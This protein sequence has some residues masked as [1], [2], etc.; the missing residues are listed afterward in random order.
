[1]G[2]FDV[3]V[4]YL[5]KYIKAE[6]PADSPLKGKE[7]DLVNIIFLD[8][9]ISEKIRIDNYNGLWSNENTEPSQYYFKDSRYHVRAKDTVIDFF[10]L[11]IKGIILDV[12]YTMFTQ[13]PLDEK[14]LAKDSIGFIL[15][16]KRLLKQYVVKLDDDEYCVYIKLVSHFL[17][18]SS[19]DVSDVK[20]YFTSGKCNLHTKWKC[21]FFEN[22]TCTINDDDI[23]RIM[24]KLESKNVIEP[25]IGTDTRYKINY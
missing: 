18:H 11:I 6:M 23:D 24:K 13:K 7:N 5:N 20:G 1:M 19:F 22:E 10:N 9:D 12:V 4:E 16:I 21:H 3:D 8:V 14:S 17:E 2:Y 25:V 15:F